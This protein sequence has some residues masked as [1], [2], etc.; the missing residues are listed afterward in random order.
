MSQI[1]N[2]YDS[3]EFICPCCGEYSE[4][5]YFDAS[6]TI[7]DMDMGRPSDERVSEY[8]CEH[9]GESF[10]ITPHMDIGVKHI[11]TLEKEK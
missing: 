2:I 1:I 7:E 5:D 4:I 9:C 3:L 8:T 11:T 10:E 6:V